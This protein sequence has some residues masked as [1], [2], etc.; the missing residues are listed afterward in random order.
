MVQ[1]FMARQILNTILQ[2]LTNHNVS[3]AKLDSSLTI[4]KQKL[5]LNAILK[6]N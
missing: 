5:A 6:V 1:D 3:F 4:F 2:K